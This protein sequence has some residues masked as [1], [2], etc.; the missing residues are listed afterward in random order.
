MGRAMN[1]IHT[2]TVSPRH[3]DGDRPRQH[4]LAIAS[5]VAAASLAL[6]ACG[7]STTSS[8][9]APTTSPAPA[10]TAAP[11]ATSSAADPADAAAGERNPGDLYGPYGVYER[12]NFPRGSTGTTVSDGVVRGTVNGYLFG[13][14]AGQT[15]TIE[16]VS[17][18]ATFDLYGPDDRLLTGGRY[19]LVDPLDLDG[20]YLVVVQS[21]FGNA[22]FDLIA[23]ITGPVGGDDEGAAEATSC[24][25]GYTEFDGTYPLRICHKGEMVSVLQENLVALGYDIE[26]DGYFGEATRAALAEEFE[27]GVG[28]I[29][30]PADME[31][32][33]VCDDDC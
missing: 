13:A 29:R 11:A 18:N 9:N 12:V 4:R 30:V 2:A 5:I 1:E 20:D 23:E 3:H 31:A 16:L 7:G 6:A 24:P 19:A 14:S 22:S 27:D 33:R 28:E 17:D 21:E 10:A 26:V 15:M 32:L 8:T 25:V